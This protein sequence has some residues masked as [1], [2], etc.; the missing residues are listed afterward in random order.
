MIIFYW[1]KMILVQDK[2]PY[3]TRIFN[4][5]LTQLNTPMEHVPLEIV[6]MSYLFLN[7]L[8]EKY[9]ESMID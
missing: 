4:H 8:L 5:L 3:K 2:P 7:K 6:M 1:L 9:F